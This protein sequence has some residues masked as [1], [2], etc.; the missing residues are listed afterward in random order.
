MFWSISEIGWW[1]ALPTVRITEGCSGKIKLL[2]FLAMF[3][4]APVTLLLGVPILLFAV[5]AGILEDIFE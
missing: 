4:L 1:V 5:V 2:G 3:P